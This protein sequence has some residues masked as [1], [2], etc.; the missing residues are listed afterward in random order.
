MFKLMGKR[1]ASILCSKF[2]LSGS[3]I[4]TIQAVN[5][6]S[7]DLTVVS[8]KNNRNQSDAVELN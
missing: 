8:P 3:M 6:I 5:N 4:T 2:C 7:A 1:I